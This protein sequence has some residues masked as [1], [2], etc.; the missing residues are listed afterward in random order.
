M[1]QPA[2]S[3]RR[4]MGG[5]FISF[6]GVDCSG[7]S[8]QAKL[9]AH[10]LHQAGFQVL[11]TREPGGTIV[12]EQLRTIV[13]HGAGDEHVCDEAELL[14]FCASRVQLMRQVVLPFLAEGGIVIC[15]RFADSTTAYQGYGRGFDLRVLQHLHDLA[16][17][18]RWPD[19]TFMLDLSVEEMEQRGQMRLET[20]LVQD[21]FEDTSR[22][23]RNTVRNGYLELTRQHPQ[24]IKLINASADV[25][26]V[27]AQIFEY[28]NHA[29]ARLCPSS[30]RLG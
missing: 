20:L 7:K 18:G 8:T 27:Q 22:R 4:V 13:K 21:R 30:P 17:T 14:L 6:E 5:L 2:E 11:E 16:T 9:L 26:T 1:S 25:D 10:Q 29:I 12:G 15:D 19:L 23:F 24:R 28:M 3:H